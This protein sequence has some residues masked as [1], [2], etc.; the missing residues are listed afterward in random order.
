MPYSIHPSG[1]WL[2]FVENVAKNGSDLM[3]LPIEGD[4]RGGWHP[5]KSVP[6]LQTPAAETAPAFSPDG[7]WIAY[8]S[9]Q[10][11]RSEI[12]VQA[13]P[14]APRRWQVSTDGG[15]LP[16]WQRTG[17]ELI[18]RR[19]ASVM[20]ASI[21]TTPEF[22]PGEPVTLFETPN[23]L[24]DVLP[25]GG[26]LMRTSKPTPP[27]TELEIVVNWFTELLRKAGGR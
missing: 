11:G 8:Q 15:T 5:G 1:Q 24:A 16:T 23:A 25:D 6:F 19:G 17:R 27:V 13:F 26:L 10:S 14:T 22:H 3:L 20:A 12:Y 7:R 18:Y 2:A 9:S 21:T 4:E